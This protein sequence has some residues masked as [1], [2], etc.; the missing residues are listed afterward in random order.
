MTV[1]QSPLCAA[2][3]MVA[4]DLSGSLLL[5]P[6]EIVELEK[7][8]QV[9]Q[10]PHQTLSD[11]KGR[12]FDVCRHWARGFCNRGVACG[13]AH[14]GPSPLIEKKDDGNEPKSL[15]SCKDFSAGKCNRG[16]RC[17]F[18]HIGTGPRRGT[19]TCRDW[20]A[21]TCN[22]GDSC[23]YVHE[24]MKGSGHNRL[25]PNTA[26]IEQIPRPAVIQVP[27]GPIL[28]RTEVPTTQEFWPQHVAI[29]QPVPTFENK[30]VHVED[31]AARLRAAEMEL[32]TLR[33]QK[34]QEHT[35]SI[36]ELPTSS[37]GSL[38]TTPFTDSS[39]TPQSLCIDSSFVYKA[40]LMQHQPYMV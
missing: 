38:P 37:A 23:K 36:T 25:A 39:M 9:S 40:P 16:E 17:K 15:I 22:R 1:T 35:C 33:N 12:K 21:G 2:S 7:G 27:T 10:L 29:P 32:A 11:D 34:Q 13:F 30:V 31:M 8:M 14:V 6:E 3:L 18:A 19:P 4:N 28:L 24:G 5:Q 26:T 20:A